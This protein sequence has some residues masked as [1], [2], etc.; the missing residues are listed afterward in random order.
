MRIDTGVVIRRDRRNT[1]HLL[2]CHHER[3]HDF[4]ISSTEGDTYHKRRA[5]L[6]SFFCLSIIGDA[7][8][9]LQPNRGLEFKLRRAVRRG[10]E[11]PH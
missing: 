7:F 1:A 11:A 3:I 2:I 8:V 9:V 10:S 6:I 5:F 4:F